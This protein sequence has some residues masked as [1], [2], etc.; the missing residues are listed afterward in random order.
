MDMEEE[1]LKKLAETFLKSGL[2]TNEFD[3]ME[4]A[5]ASFG[6]EEI[7]KKMQSSGT[8]SVLDKGKTLKDAMDEGKEELHEDNIKENTSNEEDIEVNEIEDIEDVKEE[9]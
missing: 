4:K 2:A 7:L 9:E 8:N 1:K 3:A 5:K 6:A